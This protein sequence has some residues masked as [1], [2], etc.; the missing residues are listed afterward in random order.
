[1]PKDKAG[2]KLTFKEWMQ[3]WSRGIEGITPLQQVNIQ[4]KGTII[5]ILGLL[6]GIVISILGFSNL[7]WLMIIL[8]GGLFN[9]VVQ[10]VGQWQKKQILKRL[11]DV[12]E[13]PEKSAVA[14]FNDKEKH[15]FVEDDLI[16]LKGVDLR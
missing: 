12:P 13:I 11:F 6:C 16:D 15:N 7:W 5:I 1:M 8:I 10:W 4:L 3:R 2:N 14:E 9:A